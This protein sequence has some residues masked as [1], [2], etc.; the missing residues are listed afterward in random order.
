MCIHWLKHFTIELS[1]SA[2]AAGEFEEGQGMRAS[3][4]VTDDVQVRNVKFFIDGE[5]VR[6]DGN[7][8]FVMRFVTPLIADAGTF[9]L[10]AIATDTGGNTAETPETTVTLAPDSRPPRVSRALPAASGARLA[11]TARFSCTCSTWFEA[12]TRWSRPQP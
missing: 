7:F 8:P 5:L 12:V 1:T 6:T 11:V 9:T 4:A 2:N 3:A 10:K